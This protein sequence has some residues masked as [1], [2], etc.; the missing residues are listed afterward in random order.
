MLKGN[1]TS[2]IL[3]SPVQTFSQATKNG[4]REMPQAAKK[5]KRARR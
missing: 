1:K 4:G 5:N 2:E 3:L